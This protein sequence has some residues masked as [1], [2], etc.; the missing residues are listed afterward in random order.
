LRILDTNQ[1]VVKH[2]DSLFFSPAESLAI[3]GRDGRNRFILL[4]FFQIL[5]GHWFVAGWRFRHIAGRRLSRVRLN[6]DFPSGAPESASAP[7]AGFAGSAADSPSRSGRLLLP[8]ASPCSSSYSESAA[9]GD[10]LSTFHSESSSPMFFSF[11]R[12]SPR[13]D[14]CSMKFE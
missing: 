1:D 8:S 3:L 10:S 5:V 13:R 14:E 2:H 4:I 11:S 7:L 6:D 9:S 12:V